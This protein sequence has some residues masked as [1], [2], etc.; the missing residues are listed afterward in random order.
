[1]L[2]LRKKT[3]HGTFKFL[4][5]NSSFYCHYVCACASKSLIIHC[6]CCVILFTIYTIQNK[7]FFYERSYH[8]NQ[9]DTLLVWQ[10][11][12]K[13]LSCQEQTEKIKGFWNFDSWNAQTDRKVVILRC[14]SRRLGAAVWEWNLPSSH[15]QS[16]SAVSQKCPTNLFLRSSSP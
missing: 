7:F 1:M 14:F 10:Q 6:S 5:L 4:H 9:I 2:I 15:Q 8:K 16:V 13:T 3:L 11:L 12:N